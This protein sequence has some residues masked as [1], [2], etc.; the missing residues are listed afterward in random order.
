MS[1]TKPACLFLALAYGHCMKIT[2]P[3]E[4]LEQFKKAGKRGGKSKSAVKQA[5][6][7]ANGLKGGRPKKK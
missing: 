6:A 2:L 7:K 3:P 4:I 5:A 1:T